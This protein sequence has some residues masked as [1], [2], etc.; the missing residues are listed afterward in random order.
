MRRCGLVLILALTILSGA[1][2]A[3]TLDLGGVTFPPGSFGTAVVTNN[4]PSFISYATGCA[5]KALTPDGQLRNVTLQ[6][7]LACDTSQFMAPGSQHTLSFV[8]PFSP[9]TYILLFDG[10]LFGVRT[11]AAERLDVGIPVLAAPYLALYPTRMTDPAEAHAMDFYDPGQTPWEIANFGPSIHVFGAGDQIKILTPGATVPSAVM[12]L[13]GFVV[14][15]GGVLEF[16]LPVGNLAPGPYTIESSW[17]D[18]GISGTRVVTHGVRSVST[19]VDLHLNSGS[20]LTASNPI[21][22]TLVVR[23]PGSPSPSTAIYAFLLGMIPGSTTLP[24]GV[25]LPLNSDDYLLNV[26]LFGDLGGLLTN[27]V[28]VLPAQPI[29]FLPTLV[30]GITL[31]HPGPAFSGWKIRG[32]ALVLDPSSGQI[33]ASQPEIITI[34]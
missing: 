30:Q 16:P 14:P 15:A 3:Q 20:I 22:A 19:W 9:G 26:T 6:G 23:K 18:P 32:A 29:P 33:S 5:L 21:N 10:T 4:T 25:L 28:G 8:T 17:F 13:S 7:S 31:Q 34:Q 24:D 2:S 27:H 1:G 11:R 12:Q